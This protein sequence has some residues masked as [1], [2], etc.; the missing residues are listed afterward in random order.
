VPQ[1]ITTAVG[2]NNDGSINARPSNLYKLGQVL[3]YRQ[4]VQVPLRLK[5]RLGFI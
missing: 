2:E 3:V 5:V 1:V 4:K